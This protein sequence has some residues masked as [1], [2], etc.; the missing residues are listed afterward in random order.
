MAFR[1]ASCQRL[2]YKV[3][4]VVNT[5]ALV[6]TENK[7]DNKVFFSFFVRYVAVLSV[8]WEDSTL[9]L[10]QSS[11]DVEMPLVPEL[12]DSFGLKS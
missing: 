4:T 8:L 7:C 3:N 6:K 2:L 9:W 1:S 12:A 11:Y 10:P 5:V